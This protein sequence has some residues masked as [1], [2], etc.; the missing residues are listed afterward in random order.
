[1]PAKSN[2]KKCDQKCDQKSDQNV[3]H[4]RHDSNMCD[5]LL[6]IMELWTLKA[7]HVCPNCH[8]YI[9]TSD[10]VSWIPCLSESLSNGK[11]IPCNQPPQE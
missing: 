7:V 4:V 2:K 10:L 9:Y 1:M 11:N 5:F 8:I 3:I 6:Y